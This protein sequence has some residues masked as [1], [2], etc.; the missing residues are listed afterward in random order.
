MPNDGATDPVRLTGRSDIHGG[1]ASRPCRHR[2]A[3]PPRARRRAAHGA[4]GARTPRQ[5]PVARVLVDVPLAHLDRPYDYL[6][7]E[8]DAAAARPGV[9]VR[10][11]FAGRLVE[12]VRARAARRSPTTTAGSAS[13]SGWCRRSRC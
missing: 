9:R 8:P 3:A 13:S 1:V 7:D 11:R 4:P 5:L 10:V 12:R 6:V 2:R